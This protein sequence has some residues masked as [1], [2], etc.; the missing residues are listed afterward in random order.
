MILH[1]HGIKKI[2]EYTR[3]GQKV[4]ENLP[5]KNTVLMR[6]FNKICLQID[7]KLSGN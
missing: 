1:Y 7:K 6:R 2:T 4:V 3:W 5:Y